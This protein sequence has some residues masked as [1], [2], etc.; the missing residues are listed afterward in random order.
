MRA[1]LTFALVAE[2]FLLTALPT[3]D[4][5]AMVACGATG[6]S[7]G[8]VA[9]AIATCLTV[10][11]GVIAPAEDDACP[12]A[13]FDLAV[14]DDAVVAVFPSQV[15]LDYR[16][17]LD[18]I[19]AAMDGAANNFGIAIDVLGLGPEPL[20]K[21]PALTPNAG[22]RRFSRSGRWWRRVCWEA[23]GSDTSRLVPASSD[24]PYP[25]GDVVR[26]SVLVDS[27][28]ARL[29][30]PAVPAFEHT[31]PTSIMQ[32]PTWFWADEVWWIGPHRA[33]QSHGRVR[34]VVAALPASWEM[35]APDGSVLRRCSR[36]GETWSR[37]RSDADGCTYT[38]SDPVDDGVISIS[39]TVALDVVWGVSI[40]GYGVQSLTPLFRSVVQDHKVVE[41]VGLR[42]GSVGE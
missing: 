26:L 29:D 5:H 10:P 39:F 4:A 20:I 36:R 9:E 1:K 23:S 2:L 21:G 33:E 42:P 15:V 22:E 27:A 16:P 18:P 31:G 24:G 11:D 19:A 28:R 6:S 25:E 37:G 8:V 17:T 34:V 14:A 3:A 13:T 40:P 12:I 35:A 41:V 38:F 30:P 32:L 7:D